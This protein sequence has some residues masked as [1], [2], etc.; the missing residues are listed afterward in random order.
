MVEILDRQ[1]AGI[2]RALADARQV[3]LQFT[4]AAREE[5][6]QFERDQKFL[7]LRLGAIMQERQTEPE[8][9]RQGYGVELVRFE[10]MGILYLWPLEQG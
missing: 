8:Q 7:D 9:I 10:P 1:E 4:R 6:E 2:R 5:R 3:Q